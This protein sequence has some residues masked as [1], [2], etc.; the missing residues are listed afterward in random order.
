MDFEPSDR[1]KDLSQR[2]RAFM[3]EHIYPQELEIEEALDR[4]VSTT[5]AFPEILVGIRE[6]AKAEG[7][8]N[9]FLPDAEDGPGLSNV[10]YGIVNEEIGRATI[11]AAYAFNCQPPDSGNMEILVEHA[12]AGQRERWLHPLLEGQIRSC[13]SMTE[14]ETAGNDPTGLKC[15]AVR[16]GDDWVINGRKWWTTNALGASVAIVMAVT[17]P[18]APPH[19]RATMLLVPTDAPG[20]NMV[21]PLSNM[22]HV[23]GPGHWEI[24]YEDCRVPV[25]EATLNE[26]GSGFKVSQD[27][28][29]PGRIHHCM[30]LIGV[31]ERALEMMCDRAQSRE[32]FGT[33]LSDRQFIQDFIATSRAEIDQAKLL[34]LNAAWRLD[35]VGNREARRELSV[36]K[37]VVPKTVLGIVDRAIQVFGGAGV[38]DDTPLSWM[39]RYNRMLRIGDGGDEVHKQV[40]AR[41]ELKKSAARA[42][43]Q[44]AR[45]EAQ[46]PV[47][48]G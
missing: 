47:T 36:T 37:L 46:T 27:R 29:G 6:K 15:R 30:R 20:F 28:L 23:D 13:F 40:I 5:V 25:A 43:A 33:K 39:Y 1:A 2:V 3:D 41:F 21:R 8:W 34:T 12:D 48:A 4:E 11:P 17:D 22:G 38:S 9:L 42:E 26:V 19:K 31:A 10:D 24:A 32:M 35:T 16:D 14:P 18:D 44:A 7:L 45:A